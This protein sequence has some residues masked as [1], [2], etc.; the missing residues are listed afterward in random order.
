MNVQKIVISFD[1]T[2]FHVQSIGIEASTVYVVYLAVILI[3]RFG[4]LLSIRQI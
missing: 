2:H 3:W 1:I 4:D